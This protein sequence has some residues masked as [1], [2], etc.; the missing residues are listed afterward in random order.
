[1]ALQ[2]PSR[3]YLLDGHQSRPK[4]NRPVA[5][6]RP[7]LS[8]LTQRD[9][10]LETSDDS[11]RARERKEKFRKDSP[12]RPPCG[13]DS[14]SVRKVPR[15]ASMAR[16]EVLGRRRWG[17]GEGE[18]KCWQVYSGCP[19]QIFGAWQV[20]R[21]FP[22]RN[23]A[24]VEELADNV[25]RGSLALSLPLSLSSSARSVSDSQDY[26][27]PV[28]IASLP[29]VAR[30]PVVARSWPADLRFKSYIWKAA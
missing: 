18:R 21:C 19:E 5:R 26:I 15:G 11:R 27:H 9:E 29:A 16:N 24:P 1:M 23:P 28:F 14:L 6:A 4:K 20:L 7:S 10:T 12:T 3:L 13:L 8:A 25:D 17:W 22:S 30:G 2:T